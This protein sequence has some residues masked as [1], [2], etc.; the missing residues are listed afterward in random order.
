MNEELEAGAVLSHYRILSKIGS[1]GMGVVYLAEDTKLDRKV[2]LKILLP[3]VA[4]DEER[5]HRFVQEAKSA[6]ALNHPNIL[7]VFEIGMADGMRYIATEFIK[8][9][10][11]RQRLGQE[12]MKLGNALE[13]TL[14]VTAAL[15]AAHEAGIVHRDIKPENIMIRDDGLVKVLDFGLAKLTGVPA[16]SIDTTI[17]QF[18]TD[19]GTLV[20]TVAYMSP[21][22]AR[23]RDLDARSDIF[24][25]GIVMFELFT[26][27]RPFDGESHLELISSILKDKAPG[28]REVAPDMPR[29]LDR[30]VEKTLRKDRDV[31]Y[32]SVKDLHIDMQD[33]RD[34]LKFE[35]KFNQPV[36]PTIE[37]QALVTNPSDLRSAFTGLSKTRRFTLLHALIF[38]LVVTAGVG[39]A[40][41]TGLIGSGS[42]TVAP[43]SYKA[44]EVASWNS[45]PG[46]LFSSAKFSP[47]G[48]L[49]AFS[50]TKSGTRNIWV[51][52]ANS[53]EAIQITNDQFVNTDPIWSPKGDEV[54]Y[55]SVRSAREGNASSVGI[56][57]VPA[58]GG[59]PRSVA[60]FS[61]MAVALRRW[62]ATGKIYYESGG[63]LHAADLAT[64]SQQKITSLEQPGIRWIDIS[65]DEKTIAYVVSEKD[66]WRIML[67][68]LNGSESIEVARGT[69]RTDGWA[70]LPEKNRFFYGASVNEIIQ[71]FLKDISRG[72]TRQITA[73][74][75]DSSVA[76][77]AVDGKSILFCS[78]K[79][80]SNLWQVSLPGGLETPLARDLNAKLWPS[81]S[82]D[83]TQVTYQS[84]RNLTNGNKL[85][86]GGSIV[87]K[88]MKSRE[89]ER[90]GVVALD[91]SMPMWAPDGSLIAFV[92]SGD[93]M[94]NLFSANAFGGAEQQITLGGI[95]HSGYAVS[96]YNQPETSSF[97]WSPDSSKIA[98]AS[99]RE[100][101]SNIWNVSRDG[102]ER[103]ITD[104]R[105]DS[106]SYKCPLWDK[107]GK[108]I[109]F[110]FGKKR[111]ASGRSATGLRIV[112]VE[113]GATTTIV[114]SS[115]RIRLIGW[116]QDENG[117]IFAETEKIEQGPPAEIILKRVALAGNTESEIARL[118]N[119]YYFNIFLS[120]DGKNLA[121]A[122]R[123]DGLDNLWMIPASGGTARKV[124]NNSDSGVSYSR[125]AW[126]PD[127][128]SLVVGKQTRF[129]LL[130]SIS[131]I[132]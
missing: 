89:D 107:A 125:L 112:D 117:L 11:L 2:A 46:E 37:A 124:T 97:S 80:E 40:W 69:G 68:D 58:L 121:F 49:I 93:D 15:C 52:Q 86:K 104:N 88:K 48:R 64:G 19:P 38:V 81:I 99:T 74:E 7:T 84:I 92:K 77:A 5:V 111:D 51:T 9:D 123:N 132:Q 114:E 1:G 13:I 72:E 83:N 10:T 62:T 6:S 16:A 47:D 12:P 33:L 71:I 26:G 106:F 41:Y 42:A 87:V 57:R 100:K 102:V 120:H 25:L 28:L 90:P 32:Q 110:G 56:W 50:S 54:A 130:S 20:G 24:S 4:G 128:S 129:S 18:N 70:W 55:F 108:R 36:Q 30:M 103:Q 122:A 126:L 75:T 59:G 29:H 98:Y 115:K 116:T 82:P 85:L 17:P 34:E 21:E 8:G 113:T 119:T 3:A 31:R 109:A 131:G 118:K 22:Q 79:E 66:T 63:E 27:R 43:G 23:G 45:A 61:H 95:S 53:T 91:G 67:R 44:A 73:F 65:H 76:D 78:A 35:E 96:P 127:G 39:A 94:F 101:I 105:D 60:T 14:Q